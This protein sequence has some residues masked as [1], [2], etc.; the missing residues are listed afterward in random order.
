MF[1]CCLRCNCRNVIRAVETDNIPLLINL[2][3]D[4]K[5]VPSVTEPWS[6]DAT[7]IN[8]LEIIFKNGKKDMLEKVLKIAIKNLAKTE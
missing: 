6:T 4:V 2:I 1:N 3:K 7:N 8:P 5:N